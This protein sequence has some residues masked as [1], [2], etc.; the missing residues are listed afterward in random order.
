M[1]RRAA[2]AT[3]NALDGLHDLGRQLGVEFADLLASPAGDVAV[4][5][6]AIA[7]RGAERMVTPP[8]PCVQ[9]N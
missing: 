8:P 6:V 1:Y 2:E 9:G 3:V 5:G 7:D 4:V